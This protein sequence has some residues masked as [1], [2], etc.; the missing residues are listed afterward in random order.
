MKLTDITI[1]MPLDRILNELAETMDVSLV[2]SGGKWTLTVCYNGERISATNAF[3]LYAVE[4]V[5]SLLYD[6][7]EETQT[8]KLNAILQTLP[9]YVQSISDGQVTIS[10][11]ARP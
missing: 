5:L 7:V 6:A 2:H 1:D 4:D 9:D 3:W 8:K 10:R 11:N